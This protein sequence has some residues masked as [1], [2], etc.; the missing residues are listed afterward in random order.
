MRESNRQLAALSGYD[1]LSGL[2]SR[3]RAEIVLEIEARKHSR[4]QSTFSL[5]LF[6]IDGLEQL[7]ERHGEDFAVFVVQEVAALLKRDVRFVDLL[8]R[9][10]DDMFGVLLP[11]TS[12]LGAVRQAERLRLRMTA[13]HF[14]L[15][16]IHARLTVSAGVA[17]FNGSH[18]GHF[19]HEVR[20]QLTF[21]VS[22]GGNC[23]M[24]G[25]T[26]RGGEAGLN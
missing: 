4:Y 12:L 24:F 26:I 11:M 20:E 7:K 5:V 18:I 22:T 2:I 8:C 17:E 6:R 21:A 1:T 19:M 10:D 25:E 3:R 9:W 15:D 23:V 16:G 13:Q 14:K